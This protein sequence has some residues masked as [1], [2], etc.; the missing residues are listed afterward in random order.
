MDNY[1]T[2]DPLFP[3]G[4]LTENMKNPVYQANVY[5]NIEWDTIPTHD[6]GGI[7]GLHGNSSENLN[8]NYQNTGDGR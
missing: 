3:N 6:N 5:S 1:E 7:A 8:D 2:G 4:V